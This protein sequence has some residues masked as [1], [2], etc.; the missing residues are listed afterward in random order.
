LSEDEDGDVSEEDV[1]MLDELGLAAA[2]LGRLDEKSI[3]RC[4]LPFGDL[5][6]Y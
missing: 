3:T 1:E 6:M 5:F 2:F 4:V